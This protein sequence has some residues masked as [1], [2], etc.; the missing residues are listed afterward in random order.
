[1]Y[2]G[3]YGVTNVNVLSHFLGRSVLFSSEMRKIRLTVEKIHVEIHSVH[4]A[5]LACVGIVAAVDGNARKF[6]RRYRKIDTER[7]TVLD[8][9]PSCTLSPNKLVNVVNLID[10]H[11]SIALGTFETQNADYSYVRH[12]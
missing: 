10:T 12:L 5:V 7:A 9:T 3:T 8:R 4:Y 2:T 1:M 11:R 6:L